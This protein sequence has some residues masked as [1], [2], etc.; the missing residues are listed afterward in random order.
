MLLHCLRRA[1]AH[2]LY[3]DAERHSD[4]RARTC[5]FL[6]RCQAVFYHAIS[7]PDPEAVDV[8]PL[9]YSSYVRHMSTAGSW[10]GEVEIIAAALAL[11][12]SVVLHQV[13][14]NPRLVINSENLGRPTLH[15]GYVNGNHYVSVV[16][17]S[18]VFC[19]PQSAFFFET[20]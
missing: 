2:Q 13:G 20:S 10:G 1:L 18:Y 12:V 7:T 19:V 9:D 14:F 3:G 4:I 6:G 11:D 16:T 8:A 15:I 5:S 17:T